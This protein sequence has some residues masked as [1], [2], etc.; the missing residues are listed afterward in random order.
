M[1]KMSS[2]SESTGTNRKAN[3]VFQLIQSELAAVQAELQGDLQSNVQVVSR[4]G[5]YILEAGGKRVRPALL[6]LS[7][8]AVNPTELRPGTIQLAAVIELIH[9]ATLVHDDI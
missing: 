2:I 8:R 3:E 6:L 1:P 4:I 7:A 9:T 5:S